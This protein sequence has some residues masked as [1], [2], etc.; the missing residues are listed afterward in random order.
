MLSKQSCRSKIVGSKAE[1]GQAIGNNTEEN[2]AAK[3]AKPSLLTGLQYPAQSDGNKNVQ[4]AQAWDKESSP[5]KFDPVHDPSRTAAEPDG[6]GTFDSNQRRSALEHSGVMAN[7]HADGQSKPTSK[8][9]EARPHSSDSKDSIRDSQK[10]RLIS[11]EQR[12]RKS[13]H[14]N[15]QPSE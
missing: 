3:L 4:P 10:P 1:A 12:S 9:Q 6:A 15:Y 7:D 5:N 2:Y 11:T 13:V 14:G 8:D